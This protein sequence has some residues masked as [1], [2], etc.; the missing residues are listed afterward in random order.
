MAETADA[1]VLFGITGDL[2]RRKLFRALYALELHG[3]LNFPV[4]GVAS[5]PWSEDELRAHVREAVASQL[6]LDDHVFDDLA[7]R[8]RYVSGDYTSPS[9]FQ[10]LNECLGNAERIVCYLAIPPSMFPTVIEGLVSVGR[11]EGTTMVLEKPFGRDLTSARELNAMLH[12]HFPEDHIFRIDHFLGKEPVQNLLVYRFA[13]TLLEPLWNR[14]YIRGVQVTMSETFGV[15][16][17]GQF[18]DNVGVL[19]DVVQNHLLEVVTLL[20]MEPP[21]DASPTS[22][23]DERVKVMRA[24]RS[25]TPH[26][27]VRGQY[28]GYLE[29]EGV[30]AASTTET[31]VA[32]RLHIDSWRWAGVPWFIRAGKS[33]RRTAT[34]ATVELQL[35]PRLLFP[36]AEYEPEP[37]QIRFRLHPEDVISLRTQAKLPGEQLVTRSVTLA[38]DHGKALGA[39]QDAY[40]RLLADALEGDTSLFAREDSVE[41][42]WRIVQPVLDDP[43]DVVEYPEGSWGP[44]EAAWLLDGW[45][46]VEPGEHPGI[47]AGSA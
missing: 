4:V 31:F 22:L 21:I 42:A 28:T 11:T 17:R 8:L 7:R 14:R 5:S 20:A 40:E 13:N 46:W 26:D 1:L 16:G 6:S 24:I 43:P 33:L 36:D 41:E 18:Y 32:M 3:R 37:N 12:Q 34:E 9:T 23:C 30:D 27:I 45:H 19:R 10:A 35:P 29:E 39:G 38:V 15:D 44:E 25:L 2:A 47:D